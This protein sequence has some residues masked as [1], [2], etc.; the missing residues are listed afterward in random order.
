MPNSQKSFQERGGYSSNFDTSGTTGKPK[1]AMISHRALSSNALI[2]RKE[3]CFTSQDV[4]IHALPVFHTHG[5]FVA[6]NVALVSGA[7]LLFLD[8]FD[9]DKIIKA[10]PFATSLMG[11]PTFTHAS[12][13][14]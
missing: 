2:L 1:G 7:K 10:M 13:A 3:W 12:A 6:T 4:L 8:K 11:V 5:L 14:C 9:S